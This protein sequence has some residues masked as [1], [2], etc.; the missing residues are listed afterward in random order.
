MLGDP[1]PGILLPFSLHGQC[2]TQ[3]LILTL[4]PRIPIFKQFRSDLLGVMG[5]L[6]WFP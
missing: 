4:R 6:K 2:P 1:T 3:C 5:I